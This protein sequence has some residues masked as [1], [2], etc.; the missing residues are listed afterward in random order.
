MGWACSTHGSDGSYIETPEGEGHFAEPKIDGM[1]IFKM[2]L[3][4]KTADRDWTDV[5]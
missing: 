4:N 3:R 2:I 5:A 1:I